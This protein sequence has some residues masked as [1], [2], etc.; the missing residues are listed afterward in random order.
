MLVITGASGHIG[1][2]A[3]EI[4]LDQGEQV[5]VIGRK[6]EGL[7]R[8]VK[9]GA[10]EMIGNLLDRAFLGRAFTGA[11]AVFALIPPNYTAADF[12]AYQKVVGKNLANAIVDAGVGHVVNLSS[13]G[14]ELPDGTGPILGLHD[15][16]AR[17]NALSD[18]Q[19]LHLRP[20]Y[21]MENLLLNIPLIQQQGIAGSAVR[22]D[23][24]FAMIATRD[25]AEVVAARLS[26]RD[27]AG[28]T[29]LDLLGPRDLT[30]TEATAVLGRRIGK[31]ELKYVQ[32]SIEEATRGMLAMGLSPDMVRL[33]LEMSQA[34]SDRRFAAGR[35]RTPENTTPT[36]IEAF[37]EI[38]AAAYRDATTHKAA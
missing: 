8:L 26:R 32:F 3:A 9:R 29:V 4:L 6:S 25:I 36:T 35:V 24:P 17:L 14:A 13:Q 5:R 30:L 34:I 12:R 31:P 18:V 37:A 27:F 33:Y 2:Q 10:E 38:F 19:V 21:F 22:G 1:S 7:Q 20:T 11:R 15:Q 16:E 23:V 28:K